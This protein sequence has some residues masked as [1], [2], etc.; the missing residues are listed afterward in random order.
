MNLFTKLTHSLQKQTY[1]NSLV[2]QWL[3]LST[4]TAGVTVLI[5]HQGTKILWLT[6]KKRERERKKEKKK[7]EKFKN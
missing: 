2:V 3:K 7:W 1:W 5:P 4:S 6:K